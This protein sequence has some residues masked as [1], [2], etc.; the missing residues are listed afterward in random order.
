MVMF[1][2]YYLYSNITQLFVS[3]FADTYTIE[4]PFNILGSVIVFFIFL[5]GYEMIMYGYKR[6]LSQTNLKRI[7]ESN[8]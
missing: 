7:M 2:L 8:L 1:I 6:K 3:L 5:I 4:I